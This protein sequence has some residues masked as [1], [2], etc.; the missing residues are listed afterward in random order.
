[1]VTNLNSLPAHDI[2]M[3]AATVTVTSNFG[4][5]ALGGKIW[6]SEM[7]DV[8][9]ICRFQKPSL[10]KWARLAKLFTGW[11]FS[12]NDEAI[13]L[14]AMFTYLSTVQIPEFLKYKQSLVLDVEMLTRSAK[15][16]QMHITQPWK[17]SDFECPDFVMTVSLL[18]IFP[19]S[20]ISH[21]ISIQDVL[22]IFQHNFAS[23]SFPGSNWTM[24]SLLQL[25]QFYVDFG[26][27]PELKIT[28]KSDIDRMDPSMQLEVAKE[29]RTLIEISIKGLGRGEFRKDTDIARWDISRIMASYIY[30]VRGEASLKEIKARNSY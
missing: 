1:M 2:S 12:I 22:P 18:V 23:K 11:Q 28:L 8:L 21:G 25:Y 5:L 27:I 19:L 13:E 15:L 24:E 9:M 6:T 17:E 4:F 26:N 20:H 30:I 16:L 29:I 10:F 14:E 7:L 3:G